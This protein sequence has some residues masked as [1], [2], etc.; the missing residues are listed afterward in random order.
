MAHVPYG[1]KEEAGE[2]REHHH[3]PYQDCEIQEEVAEVLFFGVGWRFSRDMFAQY[4]YSTDY[5][6][7][8][9]SHTL[10]LRYTVRFHR[11]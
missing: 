1:T 11:Q 9:A 5:G 3:Y 2:D 4:L 10:M 6:Y 8:A 7:S